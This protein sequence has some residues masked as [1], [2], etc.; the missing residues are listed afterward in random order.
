MVM[1]VRKSE[2]RQAR[3][4]RQLLGRIEAMLLRDSPRVVMTAIIAATATAGMIASVVL[5]HG[6]IRWMSLRYG[7]SV[8]FAYVAFMFFIWLWIVFKRRER[9]RDPGTDRDLNDDDYVELPGLDHA[10][11]DLDVPMPP[12]RS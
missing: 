9:Y 6:G 3:T 4:R 11:P 7:L 10:G 5:H 1:W 8:A 12:S 2:L